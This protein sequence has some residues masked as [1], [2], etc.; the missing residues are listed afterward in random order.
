MI[1]IPGLSQLQTDIANRLWG[2][3]TLEEVNEFISTLP[4]SLRIEAQTVQEMIIAAT[5]DQ[6]T[7]TDLAK[8]VLAEIAK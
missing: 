5:L 2:L 4:R 8:Q 6:Y 1:E 7:E 3:E